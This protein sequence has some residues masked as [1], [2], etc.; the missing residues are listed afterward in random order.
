LKPGGTLLVIDYA[1][2]TDEAMRDAQAD[3]WLGFEPDELRELARSAG[4]VDCRVVAIPRQYAAPARDGHVGW[5]LLSALGASGKAG[6][7]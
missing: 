3:V 1:R 6:Q 5:L 7:V 4:L 2:H